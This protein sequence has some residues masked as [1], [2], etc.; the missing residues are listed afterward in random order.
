MSLR[1]HHG[2][3]LGDQPLVPDEPRPRSGV[4]TVRDGVGA[5]VGVALG[6]APH[7][8]HHIGLLA[9]AALITGTS[10]NLL[11]YAVGLLLS[12]PM[13]LRLHRRFGTPWA[14]AIAVA[15]FTALFAV[16][17]FVIGPAISG[18]DDAPPSPVPS[19]Q[20]PPGD[21]SSHH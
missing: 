21:H 10:G 4:R 12:M 1:T 11:F 2:R 18:V 8:L 15:V 3:R 20:S 9:G 6:I 16:S 7:V 13:L 14:P 5:A 17:A 19:D